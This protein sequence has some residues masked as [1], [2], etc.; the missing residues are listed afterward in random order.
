MNLVHVSVGSSTV[1]NVPL[2]WRIMW[3]PC[4]CKDREYVKTSVLSTQFCYKPKTAFISVQSRPTF[5]DPM[6][7][8][9]PGLPVH[10]Q[11]LE[12]TQTHVHR[13]GDAIQPSHPLLSPSIRR[14]LPPQSFSAS[15]SFQMSQLF[16]SGGQSIGASALAS[17]LPINVQGWCPLRLTGLISLLSKGLSM[18]LI[19][20]DPLGPDRR[21]FWDAQLKQRNREW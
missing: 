12:F 8:S 15:G 2:G 20:C 9:T 3:K 6:D 10:H 7:C 16:P 19:Q 17:I 21:Y 14:L 1:T 4:V 5:C 11:L 13:I 18:C